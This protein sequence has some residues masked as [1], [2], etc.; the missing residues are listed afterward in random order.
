M[1]Y[2]NGD[3]IKP[4]AGHHVLSELDRRRLACP[5]AIISSADVDDDAA[6]ECSQHYVGSVKY[7]PFVS[8]YHQLKRL[9]EGAGISQK[10][11]GEK[12]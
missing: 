12:Q 7:D 9:L 5:S 2:L 1:P 4:D 6:R 11:D 8:T 10:E 3:Q